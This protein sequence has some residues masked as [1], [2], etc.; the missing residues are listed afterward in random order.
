MFRS[1]K[2]NHGK[3]TVFSL[4]CVAIFVTVCFVMLHAGAP[5]TVEINGKPYTLRAED[6][7][8]LAAFL[9]VC[10][11]S[12]TTCISRH[13]IKVPLH[14]NEIYERYQALQKQQGLDLVSYKGK[15]ATELIYESQG[16]YITVTV[17]NGHIIAA[18]ICDADGGNMEGI[19]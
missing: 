8:D 11:Y 10:G 5:D 9:S 3:L 7:A 19:I 15:P 1:V 14:W 12:D 13:D 6:D 2:I 18:H 4:I 16:R 17:S